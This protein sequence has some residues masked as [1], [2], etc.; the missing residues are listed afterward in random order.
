MKIIRYTFIAALVCCFALSIKGIVAPEI[1]FTLPGG[2]ELSRSEI[3]AAAYADAI[4]NYRTKIF[5]WL[6]MI[7]LILCGW[8]FLSRK[9]VV[10]GAFAG[11]LGLLG[12]IIFDSV[13]G[14]GYTMS[15][16]VT[17]ALQGHGIPIFGWSWFYL[18]ALIAL[19]IARMKK[20]EGADGDAE[21][22]I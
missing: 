19:P 21:E 3:G 17:A 15:Q 4:S 6:A 9:K 16:S 10:Y 13:N 12:Y 14:L 5:P 7:T 1:S 8:I 2:A 22:V 18:I 11:S 20:A